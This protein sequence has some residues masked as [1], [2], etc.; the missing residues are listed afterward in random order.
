MKI[1]SQLTLFVAFKSF[2]FTTHF[3]ITN[4]KDA[5]ESDGTITFRF[6][7]KSETVFEYQKDGTVPVLSFSL[8]GYG[9]SDF[10]GTILRVRRM[11][12]LDKGIYENVEETYGRLSR[13]LYAV[14]EHLQER[15][16]PLMPQHTPFHG[17]RSPDGQITQMTKGRIFLVGDEIPGDSRIGEPCSMS[18]EKD[19]FLLDMSIFSRLVQE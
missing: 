7:D 18:P 14:C 8:P 15:Y 3:M 16:G 5:I 10:V 12:F 9:K 1:N 17:S 4:V 19:I 13:D 11:P 6:S 2:S